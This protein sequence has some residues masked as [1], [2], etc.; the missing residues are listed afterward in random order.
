MAVKDVNLRHFFALDKIADAGRLSTA[1]DRVY[2]SQSALTQAL[3]K[4]ED[5]AGAPL[6]ERAGFGVTET[7]G[8][9]VSYTHLTLPTMRTV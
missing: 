1:A 8:G 3:R 5:V 9:T 4:L 2:M 6:F 7:A